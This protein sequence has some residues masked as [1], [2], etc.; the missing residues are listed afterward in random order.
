[1][2]LWCGNLQHE[3]HPPQRLHVTKRQVSKKPDFLI[4][5]AS[6]EALHVV[7]PSSIVVT[8]EH[9]TRASG[10]LVRSQIFSLQALIDSTGQQNYIFGRLSKSV[11]FGVFI[12]A[13][14]NLALVL[15][16]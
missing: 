16:A 4:A 1:M 6:S 3:C 13:V 10:Q 7:P 15:P 9:V 14:T 2:E 12:V 8:R 5:S 11:F